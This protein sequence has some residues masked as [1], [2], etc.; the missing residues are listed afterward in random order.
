MQ[1]RVQRDKIVAIAN[2]NNMIALNIEEAD[3]HARTLQYQSYRTKV[4]LIGVI[5]MLFIAFVLI[6]I[7]KAQ[8]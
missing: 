5:V 7:M 8:R 6:L 3:S 4:M 1:Q 2:T